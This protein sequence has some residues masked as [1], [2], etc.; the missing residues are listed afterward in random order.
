MPMPM[1][2]TK[3]QKEEEEE[4]EEGLIPGLPDH[5]AQLSLA[6]L[7]PKL[8]FTLSHSWRRLLYSPTFPPFNCLYAL[9]APPHSP[10]LHFH[11]YDPLSATWQ[12]L[13]PPPPEPPLLLRHP[14]F[15]SR[16][17]AVQSISL[18]GRLLL[19]AATTHNL[20]PALP[21][22]LVF[23]PPSRSWSHGPPLSPRRC[24]AHA[25]AWEWQPK[26]QLRDARFS[27]EA[28]DAVGWRG[29]LCMVNVK[30]DAAKEGVVYDVAGDFWKDMPEGMLNGWRGPVAAME[31]RLMFVV[32]EAKGAL[33]KY[34]PQQDAWEDILHNHRL[35]GAQQLVAHQ[36]KLC[37]V[38]PSGISV[39]DVAAAPPRIFPVKLPEGLEPV[40]VHVLPRMPLLH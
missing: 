27:R 12:A 33:R 3:R 5:I 17:L 16:S 37:V 8:L 38:S 34:I 18:G 22:P 21:R 13:P 7:P 14:A 4:E 15:L 24:L 1:D 28:V 11:A 6:S 36:G 26:A 29:T 35:K 40:A 19:L 31:E 20:T 32:D 9:L 39:V 23:H 2:S 10:S 30:G 25:A